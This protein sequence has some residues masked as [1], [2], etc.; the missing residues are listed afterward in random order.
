MAFMNGPFFRSFFLSVSFLCTKENH[1][2]SRCPRSDPGSLLFSSSR[3]LIYFILA[4]A[5][6]TIV[7]PTV[8]LMVGI[9]FFL[10]LN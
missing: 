2:N 9:F 6:I 7:I 1:A 5:F 8:L 4:K 3:Y 10:H